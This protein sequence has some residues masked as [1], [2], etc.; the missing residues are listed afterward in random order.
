[1]SQERAVSWLGVDQ[2]PWLGFRGYI[3][4]YTTNRWVVKPVLAPRQELLPQN[5]I[6]GGRV[7]CAWGKILAVCVVRGKGEP[8][9]Q[10]ATIMARGRPKGPVGEAD[11]VAHRHAGPACPEHSGRLPLS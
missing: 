8:A 6:K 2:K 1:V 11:E 10:T 4:N 5:D 9:E 3:N 7:C